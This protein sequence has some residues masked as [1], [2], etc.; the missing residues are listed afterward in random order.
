MTE[1]SPAASGLDDFLTQKASQ[2]PSQSSACIQNTTPALSQLR[3]DAAAH[4]FSSQ[5]WSQRYKLI[6]F[7]A[8]P[9]QL[10]VTA[11]NC[12]VVSSTSILSICPIKFILNFTKSSFLH[13]AHLIF[14]Q[15]SLTLLPLPPSFKL[16]WYVAIRCQKRFIVDRHCVAGCYK[17]ITKPR[18]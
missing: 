7:L 1:V 13:T 12:R 18:C 8:L 10:Q 6:N 5:S 17:A 15:P 11:H 9:T 4:S 14:I 3:F 16:G 2:P